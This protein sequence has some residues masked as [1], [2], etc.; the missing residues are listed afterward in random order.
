MGAVL[1]G[2]DGLADEMCNREGTGTDSKRKGRTKARPLLPSA[3]TQPHV[4]PLPAHDSPHDAFDDVPRREYLPAPIPCALHAL[5]AHATAP[6]AVEPSI[7]SRH[8]RHLPSSH[9]IC[10]PSIIS[11][12]GFAYNASWADLAESSPKDL[13]RDGFTREPFTAEQ[14]TVLLGREAVNTSSS[15][16]RAGSREPLLAE[17]EYGSR[18]TSPQGTPSRSSFT[19]SSFTPSSSSFTHP[20]LGPALD[21]PYSAS[22][23]HRCR[24]YASAGVDEPPWC[25]LA[26]CDLPTPTTAPN[27][28][29][30]DLPTPITAPSTGQLLSKRS[31]A[32]DGAVA[33][34]PSTAR[35][36]SWT[37][38]PSTALTA[39]P[40]GPRRSRPPPP[41]GL[42]PPPPLPP[43]IL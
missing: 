2:E 20:E 17:D 39:A 30:C 3:W 22:P 33:S 14:F 29:S 28:A 34:A 12:R 25:D 26:S 8:L 40:L 21:L 4:P 6:S 27:L 35:V 41:P 13:P 16:T 11:R 18:G 10:E 24:P 38:A 31:S 7:I 9:V 32:A 19:P 43:G 23:R 1:G 37:W 5:H 36:S 42:P 15:L